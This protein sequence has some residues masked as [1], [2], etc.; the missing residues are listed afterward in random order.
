MPAFQPYR[1]KPAVRNDRGIEETSAS[2]E[3][4]S[5]PRS[6][7]TTFG[8]KAD[9]T[10]SLRLSITVCQKATLA[11]QQIFLFDHLVS[12]PEQRDRKSFPLLVDYGCAARSAARTMRLTF[13]IAK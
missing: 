9:L 2:F 6:Y 1:G 3:A 4:R 8:S 7:P 12:A 10:A 5:A 13:L 11:L